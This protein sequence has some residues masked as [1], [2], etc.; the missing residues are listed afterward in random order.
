MKIAPGIDSQE[1]KRLV[2][3]PDSGNWEEGIRIFEERIKSRYIEPADLLVEN[4]SKR[5]PIDRRYGFSI[6]AID[7][8]LIETIQS[9]KE[10]RTDTKRVSKTVFVNFLTQSHEFKKH[11]MK[12]KRRSSIITSDVG[13]C[14]KLKLWASHCYGQLVC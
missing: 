3:K 13:S 11:F 14:I 5:N 6:M 10:G 2:L 8:L 7:C 9:F 12:R 1:W 4:D